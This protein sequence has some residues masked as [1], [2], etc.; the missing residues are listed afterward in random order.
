MSRNADAKQRKMKEQ[1]LRPS[2]EVEAKMH[3]LPKDAFH[4]LLN[5]AAK[6]LS[7]KPAAKSR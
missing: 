4:S 3:P 5:R 7:R 1:E 6:P 2:K